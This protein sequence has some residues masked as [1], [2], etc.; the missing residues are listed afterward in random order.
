MLGTSWPFVL[1][2]PSLPTTHTRSAIPANKGWADRMHYQRTGEMVR[3]G[4]RLRRGRLRGR[5]A[6]GHLHVVVDA[7]VHPSLTKSSAL[8]TEQDCA[9]A[10]EMVRTAI[11]KEAKGLKS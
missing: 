5:L 10:C 8:R 4:L 11:F 6:L 2:G 3:A 7:V 1:A 9:P